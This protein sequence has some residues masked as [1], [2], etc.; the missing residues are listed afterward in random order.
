MGLV[1]LLTGSGSL[2]FLLPSRSTSVFLGTGSPQFVAFMSLVS[3]RDIRNAWH[4]P[5][6]PF[7]NWI[8]D[9]DRRGPAPR[10]DDMFARRDRSQRRGFLFLALLGEPL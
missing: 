4:Y 5:A 7:L 8:P 9:R 10:R 3:Y 1:L 2:P 6:Y